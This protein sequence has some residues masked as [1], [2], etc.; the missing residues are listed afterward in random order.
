MTDVFTPEHRSRVMAA[1][2]GRGNKSTEI[3]VASILRQEGITGWR[4]HLSIKLAMPSRRQ[5][6]ASSKARSESVR[7]D[8]VF[9]EK[10]VVL[11]VDGC[12]WHKCPRHF[13]EPSNNAEFWLRKI[14]SNIERDQRVKAALRRAGWNVVR[15]W[16][17]ELTVPR[18]VVRRLRRWLSKSHPDQNRRKRE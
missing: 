3:A 12:F 16:E 7:P 18:A 15:V 11:F 9:R 13:K 6:T 4:R 1:I 17:H 8:F 2:R 10:K 14:A 5:A